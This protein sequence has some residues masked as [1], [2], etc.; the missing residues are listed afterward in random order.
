M[1]QETGLLEYAIRLPCNHIVGSGCITQWLH[2]NNTCPLCRC[3]FFPA[4]SRPYLENGIMDGQTDHTQTHRDPRVRGRIL[5]GPLTGILEFLTEMKCLCDDY[6]TQLGLQPGIAQVAVCIIANLLNPG[7]SSVI[8]HNHS[9]HCVVAV[10]IYIA[11]SLTGHSRSP[12]EI[13]AVIEDVESHHIRATYD[14]LTNRTEII[15]DG[16]RYELSEVFNVQTLIWPP[17][18]NER[19]A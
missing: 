9:D 15:D 16:I 3:V 1:S 18:G 2:S 19:T 6:C 12:S 4:Q 8:L 7:P 5:N 17:H 11:S 10:S 13:S 14:L